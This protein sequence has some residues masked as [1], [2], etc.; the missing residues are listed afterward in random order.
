MIGEERKGEGEQNKRGDEVRYRILSRVQI[1]RNRCL[2]E[3]KM[4]ERKEI[5]IKER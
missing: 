4:R 5:R 1:W 3:Y 2:S